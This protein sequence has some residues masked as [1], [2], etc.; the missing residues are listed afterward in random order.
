MHWRKNRAVTLLL[1]FTVA[2]G[3]YQYHTYIRT[4]IID[5]LRPCF[6]LF[7]DTKKK[8]EVLEVQEVR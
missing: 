7:E 1:L 4:V 3:S 6:L 5:K 8:P 2:S